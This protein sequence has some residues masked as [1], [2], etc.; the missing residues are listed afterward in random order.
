MNSF[1]SMV[2]YFSLLEGL[3]HINVFKEVI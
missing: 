2:V 3:F 1:E